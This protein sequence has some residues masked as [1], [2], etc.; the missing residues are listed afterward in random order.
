MISIEEALQRILNNVKILEPEQ[1][2]ILDCLGQVLAEDV[3]S[4]INVPPLD[5]AAMDGYAVQWDSIKGA[6]LS[7]PSMLRVIGEVAAGS[8]SEISV[9]PGTAIRIMT[10]AAVPSGADTIVPFEETDEIDCRQTLGS[11]WLAQIGIQQQLK[12]GANI[13]PA[14]EDITQ[15]ELVLSDGTVLRPPE[16][17]V[18]ASLGKEKA[19]VIRRP[20][21]TMLS[22]G[23]ELIEPGQPL[24]PGKI[25]NSNT[26]SLAAQ[27]LSYGGI[28]KVL[29]IAGDNMKSI[30]GKIYEGLDSD[31]FITSAGVSVG[32]YDIVKDILAEQGEIEFWSVKMKPGKPLAF[33][34]LNTGGRKIP[35]IGLPGNPVSAMVAFEQFGRPAILKMLGKKHPYRATIQAILQNEI[36]NKD[37]RRTLARAY[38]TKNNGKY[39]AK[40]TGS[41]GSAILTSMAQANG[42][43]IVPE[44]VSF[45]S[46]GDE[47]Q[48]QM[49]DW[50][51]ESCLV[52]TC[53]S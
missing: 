42:L 43:V 47:V 7:T 14:G 26:Y 44:H 37:G 13:R 50:G 1:K 22:T 46:T 10:G 48:V 2:P 24:Q 34:M 27:I 41:Q 40:L 30:L 5:N 25:Y 29:G 35:H 23:D 53:V 31:M 15:G 32:D 39:S 49:L 45:L 18:L 12:K 20:V 8:I 6:T 11:S 52:P 38:I 33:G 28:P 4:S 16:I 36:S 3:Y 19:Y 17:G 9:T 51:E 21:V